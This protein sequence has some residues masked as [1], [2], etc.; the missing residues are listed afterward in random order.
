MDADGEVLAV[1]GDRT[2]EG[3]RKTYADIAAY[4]DLKKRVAAGEEGL[5]VELMVAEWNL[6]K[7][8][9]A[10]AKKQ[11]DAM[12]KLSPKEQKRV[13]QIV[14]D[15]EVLERSRDMRDKEKAKDV[16]ARFKTLVSEGYIPGPKAERSFWGS[17]LMGADQA[18]DLEIYRKCV[19]KQV[20]MW[21]DEPRAEK[22]LKG[23]KDRL[24]EMEESAKGKA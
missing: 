11:A 17:L 18:N 14:L 22:Y 1:Q 24:A 12:P 3:F 7:L 10:D 4:R 5:G 19:D 21:G 16:Y 9:W 15:A 20:Q 8:T 23:L 2:V 6:G 13:A